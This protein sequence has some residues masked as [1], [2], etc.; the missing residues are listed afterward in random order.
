ME[1]SKTVQNVAIA[2]SCLAAIIWIVALVTPNSSPLTGVEEQKAVVD[3]YGELTA[4]NNT[5]NLTYSMA[6]K[7]AIAGDTKGA[8]EDFKEKVEPLFRNATATFLRLKSE[9]PNVSDKELLSETVG[10]LG[11]YTSVR[12]DAIKLFIEG[13]EKGEQGKFVESKVRNERA[14][15]YLSEAMAL[16]D[17]VSSKY[18]SNK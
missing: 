8:Y 1:K 17:Q 6:G 11:L 13:F 18:S 2:I 12:H 7:K 5:L 4:L 10:K 9:V 14:E 3:Y 15:K 16:L